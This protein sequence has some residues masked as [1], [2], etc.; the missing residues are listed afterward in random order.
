[1]SVLEAFRAHVSKQNGDAGF[2][3]AES[4]SE[5]GW[6]RGLNDPQIFRAVSAIHNHP[7]QP[8]TVESLAQHAAASRS[9]FAARFTEIVGEPP[10]RA[11]TRWRMQRAASLLKGLRVVDCRG[12]RVGGV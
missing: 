6:L 9:S 4:S 10:L 2:F 8:W 11:L 12:C 5:V 1:M 7:N 3:A